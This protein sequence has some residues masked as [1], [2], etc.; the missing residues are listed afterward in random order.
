MFS[1]VLIQAEGALLGQ[2]PVIRLHG[3]LE[4]RYRKENYK[5]FCDADAALLI[6]T[7]VAARGLHLPRVNLYAKMFWFH[8]K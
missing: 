6:C 4:Q 5:T 1:F 8:T 3:N 7:D 2:L